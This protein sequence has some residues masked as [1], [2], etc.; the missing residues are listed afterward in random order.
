[1]SVLS[2][3]RAVRSGI[4][5]FWRNVWLSLAATGIMTL[6]IVTLTL[7]LIITVLGQ[8][9]LQIIEAKVDVTVFMADDAEES[10]IFAV[11]HDIEDREGVL[12]VVYITKEQALAAF[13][14]RHKSNPLIEQALEEVGDNPLQAQLVVR[15]DSPAEYEHITE[16][17]KSPRYEQLVARVTFDDNK[18]VIERLEAVIRAV[19]TVGI[20]VVATL[21]F[22]AIL[23]TFNT[24][25]LAIYSYHREIEIM[26]LVGASSWFIRGPFV[27]E[28][29]LAGAIAACV[30]LLL[31]YPI[32]NV[33][34]PQLT[35]FFAEGQFSLKEW[36]ATNMFLIVLLT[37]GTGVLI[38]ALSSVIAVRRYL[39]A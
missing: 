23:V 17:L 31:L 24:V 6:T 21:G 25:R 1:M 9:A 22:I 15:A 3:S 10:S 30:S 8:N 12:S 28:G 29:I 2:I 7:L 34:S 14:E 37:V 13:R 33:L 11:K 18:V 5:H 16:M 26:R 27:I 38:G 39:R 32:I 4:I 35:A 20:A 19:R 36:A